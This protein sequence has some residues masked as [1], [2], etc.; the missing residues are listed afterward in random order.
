MRIGIIGYGFVGQA[1]AA[2]HNRKLLMIN[3]PNVLEDWES[4]TI[5]KIIE[6]CGWIYVCVPTPQKED[7]TCD[8]SIVESVLD[9]LAQ[10]EHT[11]ICK[12]TCPPSFYQEM[13]KRTQGPADKR[14]YKFKLVHVPEFL[15]AA[16]AQKDYMYPKLI[17]IGG[18]PSDCTNIIRNAFGSDM[19]VK[20]KTQ[21]VTT[22]I[23][24][25]AAMKYYANSWLATKVIYN[26]QFSNW[27]KSQNVDWNKVAEVAKY[28]ERLGNSHYTVPGPDTKFGYGGACF[29]KDISAILT[30][31][32][33]ANVDMSLLKFQTEINDKLR[34]IDTSPPPPPPPVIRTRNSQRDVSRP[35]PMR[36]PRGT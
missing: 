29:P 33:Q 14:K 20:T 24:T 27:C 8:T 32:D 23:G 2:N 35:T 16:N 12:S 31:A 7:G 10:Y 17:V 1:I 34:A 3:D 13:F 18:H 11:V 9:S 5:E 30:S 19:T 6:N 25:A 4:Y 22:D 15:T 21:Y 36:K 26:N 28:D